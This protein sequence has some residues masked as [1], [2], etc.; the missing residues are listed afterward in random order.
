MAR[1]CSYCG[2]ILWLALI[3]FCNIAGHA[4]A[5]D[6]SSA[7]VDGPTFDILE[8]AVEGNTVLTP[9]QIERAVYPSLGPK[10]TIRSVEEA[11]QR[12]EATYREAGYL[13]VFV[14]TPEQ[15][16]DSGIVRIVVT[17]SRVSRL[18]VL[19]AKYF[20]QGWIRNRVAAA[21][22]GEV[23]YFPDLQTGLASV[24]R[25]A[26]RQ[27]APVLKPGRTPGSI[28]VDLNVTDRS[29]LHGSIELNNRQ[30][31]NTDE[32]RLV[33]S[34]RYDNLWQREHSIGVTWLTTP[35]DTQQVSVFAANYL[36]RFP[37]TPWLFAFY[38]VR[39]RSDVAA[40]GDL[41]VLGNAN[42]AGARAIRPL[43]QVAGVTQSVSVGLDYK[44]FLE[45]L[46][47]G[48]AA[49]R[50]PIRYSPV[51]LAYQ[52]N[53]EGQRGNTRISLSTTF[54][55]RGPLLNNDDSAFA[56]KRAG[57]H[58]NFF[59][60]RGEVQRE[61]KLPRDMSVLVRVGGQMASQPLINTEQFLGGGADSVRGYLE[62][63]ALGDEAVNGGIELRVP[64]AHKTPWLGVDK[65]TILAF[66]DFA[67][68]R[69]QS[70]LPP[71]PTRTD[72][73]SAGLGLRLQS[74]RAFSASMDL[75]WPL[76]DAQSTRRGNPRLHMR[77]AYDF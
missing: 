11:R 19:G 57:A 15:S 75:G 42:I 69:S 48:S 20:S 38:A 39:S 58:A 54:A 60:A 45:T 71:T 27:V 23:P 63:E 74:G 33:G 16:V 1:S 64:T 73:S 53:R 25:S 6:V 68:L 61:Q 35:Q 43:R 2:A 29:P 44:D 22:E 37:D 65:T 8:F 49:L 41:K 66:Y 46:T 3:A 30:S 32:L 51:T 26:D 34:L 52:A 10:R 36:A 13:T 24:N 28:E 21:A 56:A 47:Q 40:V 12:L 62:V 50:T 4:I 72:L 59:L 18:S 14:D 67:R 70:V 9:L 77:V 17:E 31:P 76:E 5:D 55:L 7:P